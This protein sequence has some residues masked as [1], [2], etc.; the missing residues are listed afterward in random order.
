MWWIE[1]ANGINLRD[2]YN[3]IYIEKAKYHRIKFKQI[4]SL[5][6]TVTEWQIDYATGVTKNWYNKIKND[7]T[8]IIIYSMD[9]SG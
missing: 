3:S 6:A 9:S 4:T 7:F 5:F 2:W 1:R 8:I